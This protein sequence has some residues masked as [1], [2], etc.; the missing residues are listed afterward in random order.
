MASEL[1]PTA[2][3]GRDR[4]TSYRRF[5]R[6]VRATGGRFVDR[7]VGRGILAFTPTRGGIHLPLPTEWTA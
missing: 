1:R 2:F 5:V 7:P 6:G 4:S 3:R